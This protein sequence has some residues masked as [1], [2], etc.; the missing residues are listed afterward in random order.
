MGGIVTVLAA[1]SFHLINPIKTVCNRRAPPLVVAVFDAGL[2][3]VEAVIG[4]W[5]I[6]ISVSPNHRPVVIKHAGNLCSS[7][8]KML[9]PSAG[10]RLSCR[11]DLLHLQQ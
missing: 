3:K 10:P 4:A 2:Q 9:S 1:N 5:E 8:T 7:R 11:G 6:V